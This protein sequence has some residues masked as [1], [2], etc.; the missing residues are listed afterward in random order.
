MNLCYRAKIIIII[1]LPEL[2]DVLK[3]KQK[4]PVH[5]NL[6]IIKI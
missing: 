5:S 1:I 3:K 4:T 6:Q 2:V